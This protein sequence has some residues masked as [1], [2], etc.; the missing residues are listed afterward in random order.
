MKTILKIIG[1]IL[2]SFLC[3]GG[4]TQ[5]GISA[6]ITLDSLIISGQD[7][8]NV[9]IYNEGKCKLDTLVKL[10]LY[11][12]VSNYVSGNY[13]ILVGINDE[14]YFFRAKLTK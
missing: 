14:Q 10:P 3:F 9:K 1:L 7:T 12:D 11:L 5:K 13:L 6:T 2:L 8:A 4:T